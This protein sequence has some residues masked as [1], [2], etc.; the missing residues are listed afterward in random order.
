MSNL[1][2]LV[3]IFKMIMF[4]RL[5]HG[6]VIFGRSKVAMRPWKCQLN[7]VISVCERCSGLLGC[8]GGDVHKFLLSGGSRTSPS[9]ALQP[10]SNELHLINRPRQPE[11]TGSAAEA[12]ARPSIVSSS[13]AAGPPPSSVTPRRRRRRGDK[14]ENAWM[15]FQKESGRRSSA[16]RHF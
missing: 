4:P 7:Q 8:C 10:A 6:F 3:F 11:L 12:G 15:C 14:A 9:L 5:K 2:G 13:S 1:S 16:A